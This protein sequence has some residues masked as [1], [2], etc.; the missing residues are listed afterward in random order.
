M[1]RKNF[2][3]YVKDGLDKSLKSSKL[4]VEKY[5]SHVNT[6]SD[7]CRSIPTT[8]IDNYIFSLLI[9]TENLT[10]A[11]LKNF[12]VTLSNN[13]NIMKIKKNV[14]VEH[15]NESHKNDYN[16][17]NSDLEDRLVTITNKAYEELLK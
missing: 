2:N 14:Y 4:Q 16:E 7:M 15:L 5:L 17:Y 13:F 8:T 10:D 9:D 11:E 3:H 6:P 12:V 1:S